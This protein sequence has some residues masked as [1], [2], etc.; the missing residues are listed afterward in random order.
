MEEKELVLQ[1]IKGDEEAFGLLVKKYKNKVFNMAYSMTQNRET[2]DDISQDVFIKT[3]K[4]LPKFQ[5]K[6]QF[7][8]WLYQITVNH[9][10]DFLRKESKVKHYSLEEMQELP[11]PDKNHTHSVEK[12][13]IDKKRREIVHTTIRALP[14]KHRIILVLRDIQGYSYDDIAKILK[15]SPGTVDSRLFRARRSLRKKISP[16]L[17][18]I[19]GNHAMP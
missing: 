19:G 10:R 8:T 11:S 12:I 7:G 17:N 6:S 4:A 3:Y 2:A 18:Q 5:F 13:Q 1:S 16:F 15:I 9:I 14:E